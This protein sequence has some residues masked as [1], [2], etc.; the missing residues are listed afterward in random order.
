MTLTIKTIH[1]IDKLK[2][3]ATNNP[4]QPLC[5]VYYKNNLLFKNVYYV[6]FTTQDCYKYLKNHHKIKNLIDRLNNG[7]S[8]Q[9]YTKYNENDLINFFDPWYNIIIS[10]IGKC[11]RSIGGGTLQTVGEITDSKYFKINKQ[12]KKIINKCDQ[13]NVIWDNLFINKELDV[14]INFNIVMHIIEQN[15]TKSNYKFKNDNILFNQ[16][17]I[18]HNLYNIKNPFVFNDLL[19]ILQFCKI[20]C[21]FNAYMIINTIY[22]KYIYD[23]IDYSK[24]SLLLFNEPN[25]VLNVYKQILTELSNN[26]YII[27]NFNKK[28][29]QL[30]HCYRICMSEEFNTFKNNKLNKTYL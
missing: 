29:N 4:R 16:I 18:T 14:F 26:N 30:L 28:H 23:V 19:S 13:Y 8:I 25:N 21:L 1:D 11:G 2:L 9:I 22:K 24:Q 15:K 7:F 12:N 3:Y 5:Y 6:G 20:T 10:G 17:I 27:H